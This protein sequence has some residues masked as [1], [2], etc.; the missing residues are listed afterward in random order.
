MKIFKMELLTS[1]IF[2]YMVYML[3]VT[4]YRLVRYFNSL[5]HM[6]VALQEKETKSVKENASQLSNFFKE[7][8][9]FLYNLLNQIDIKKSL[10]KNDFLN[11]ITSNISSQNNILGVGIVNLNDKS[12]WVVKNPVIEIMDIDPANYSKLIAGWDG[13]FHSLKYKSYFI[14]LT[15]PVLDASSSTF[16][17]MDVSYD[18]LKDLLLSF[19][20]GMFGYSTIISNNKTFL[21]HPFE[22]YSKDK[23]PYDMIDEYSKKTKVSNFFKEASRGNSVY[24][25]FFDKIINRNVIA[26]S[27]PI[28]LGKDNSEPPQYSLISFEVKNDIFSDTADFVNKNF[29][30]LIVSIVVTLILLSF[31]ISGAYKVEYYCSLLWARIVTVILVLAICVIWYKVYN[32]DLRMDKSKFSL[33]DPYFFKKDSSFEKMPEKYKE[34]VISGSQTL[35]PFGMMIRN[36]EFPDG[37]H[38]QLSGY[39]WAKFPKDANIDSQKEILFPDTVDMKDFSLVS[40][41]EEG[42]KKVLVWNFLCVLSQDYNYF[43]YPFDKRRVA[44]NIIPKHMGSFL[45][46][47]A[48]SD[49]F[50]LSTLL[51]PGLI[52]GFNVW[53]WSVESTFFSYEKLVFNSDLGDS[54]LEKNDGEAYG[55]YFNIILKRYFLDAFL[56]VLLPLFVA[57]F[58]L[59]ISLIL[60]DSS[61]IIT[62]VSALFFVILYAHIALRQ[63]LA[64]SGISYIEYF[65]IFAYIMMYLIILSQVLV[66]SNYSVGFLRYSNNL[67]I[68][69][70]YWPFFLSLCFGI[71]IWLFY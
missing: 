8:Q 42:D 55:F 36:L 9:T 68:K 50:N 62:A 22:K 54:F 38:V 48:F 18:S 46:T 4:S 59:F 66:S 70:F 35:V 14:R 63:S 53:G 41:Q 44:I 56:S 27:H 40:E 69:I 25:D 12:L 19:N 39:I 32:S 26:M 49:Y 10:D 71:S 57:I 60:Q 6:N 28:N 37:S 51:K 61:Q 5:H 67:F 7:H 58:M 43:H 1:I 17:F 16:I 65:F 29:M 52:E 33:I 20:V 15:F 11:L 3:A 2:A 34:S 30:L 31:F 23:V 47:P 45:F 64:F 13:P 24:L 21:F